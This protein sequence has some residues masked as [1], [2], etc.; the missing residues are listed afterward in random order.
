MQFEFVKMEGTANDFLVTH[1]V[2]PETVDLV[3]AQA[4]SICDRR[5]GVGG[6]GIIFVLPATRPDADIRMRIF[7]SDGSEAEMCGNGVRCFAQ[8]VRDHGLFA[9]SECHVETLAG[10][11]RTRLIEGGVRVNMGIPV[12]DAPAIP[13]T[14]AAGRVVAHELTID[15]RAFFV[16]AVSMGNPHCV[17][18]VDAITDDLVLGVGP[19][20]ETHPFFPRKTNVE[21]IR[22]MNEREIEMRVWERGCGETAAC[23]TGACGAVAAGIVK[24]LHGKAVTVHL[25]GGDLF[26]EWNGGD[27][28]S[29]FMTGSARTVFTGSF[30][31][32][33][34]AGETQ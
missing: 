7:N 26:V 34:L 27:G 30:D 24:G 17:I 32:D 2:L 5:R 21:F 33:I 19:R 22:V 20:L 28:D 13:T 18:H 4:S 8:Y 12:L 15:N 14:Q 31:S 23:G 3:A 29:L 9:D 6:D 25:P 10:I 16:T 1:G 11:I